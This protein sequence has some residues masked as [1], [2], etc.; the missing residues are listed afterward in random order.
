[1]NR[2]IKA[3]LDVLFADIP[4]SERVI[5]LKA[6]LCA[7][8]SDRMD[9]YLRE[10]KS[11]H[12]AYSLAIANLGDVDELLAE[13]SGDEIRNQR[14]EVNHDSRRNA[15]L[16][17]IA[18]MLYILC[19]L[20][21]FFMVIT[22][23]NE[24]IGV[25]MLLVMVAIA[26]GIFVYMGNDDKDD[27]E[28]IGLSSGKRSGAMDGGRYD[29]AQFDCDVYVP[30]KHRKSVKVIS[31]IAWSVAGVT[32]FIWGFIFG[33]WGRAWAVFPIAGLSVAI[34]ETILELKEEL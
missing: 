21:I 14:P 28:N 30:V 24:I 32:F 10:G 9:D 15:K 16:R 19:P 18:V 12:Q 4:Q 13:L 11:E 25:A 22:N 3:Y 8:L 23:Q 26:T 6:E 27:E 29:E 2:K 5:E 17:T 20:P 34:F 31:S 1:M 33:E 7:N